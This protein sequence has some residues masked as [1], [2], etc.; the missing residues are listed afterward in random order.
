VKLDKHPDQPIVTAVYD[1]R[2]TLD[3][4]KKLLLEGPWLRTLLVHAGVP[5][6]QFSDGLF[7]ELEDEVTGVTRVTAEGR[8]VFTRMTVTENMQMGAFARNDTAAIDED[9]E[10]MS[11]ESLRQKEIIA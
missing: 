1:Q 5:S 3:R 2:T 9:M 4:R 10:R 8:G 7:F 6:Q 11:Q